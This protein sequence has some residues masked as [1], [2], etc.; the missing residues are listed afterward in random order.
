MQLTITSIPNKY[1]N[2]PGLLQESLGPEMSR[3]CVPEDGVNICYMNMLVRMNF[4][5]TWMA[6][7]HNFFFISTHIYYTKIWFQ[8]S[9][10]NSKRE[11]IFS[12]KNHIFHITICLCTKR[13]HKILINY[14][15]NNM[16]FRMCKKKP[17]PIMIENG[18][19]KRPKIPTINFPDLLWTDSV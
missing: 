14:I 12:T 18:S 15:C 11:R 2:P 13:K 6:I 1:C 10:K 4:S 8:F 9:A 3:E 7:T 17:N 5:C 19:K 16:K